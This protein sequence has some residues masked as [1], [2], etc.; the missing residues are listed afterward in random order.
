MQARDENAFAC[1]A[2]SISAISLMSAPAL[3]A[4][5]PAPVSTTARNASLPPSSAMVS[6]SAPISAPFIALRRRALS[7]VTVATTPCGRVSSWT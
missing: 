4:F 6:A 7:I 3:N 2:F 5:G 1:A